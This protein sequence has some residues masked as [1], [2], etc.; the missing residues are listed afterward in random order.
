MPRVVLTDLFVRNLKATA[1]ATYW[2]K[3]LPGFGLR[4]GKRRKTFTVMLGQ[5]R[6]RLTIGHYPA[7]TLAEARK[8]AL[9]LTDVHRSTTPRDFSF[10]L[11][12][13]IE[14]HC[15]R[16]NKPSTA[17]ET[18]RL[19]RRLPF[20]G[21][22]HEITKTDIKQYLDT[23]SRSSANHAFTA[24]KTF[25]N[26]CVERDYLASNP[27]TGKKPFKDGSRERALSLDEVAL[28]LRTAD[29]RLHYDQI[30][31]LLLHTG[32]RR[33]EIAGLRREFVH[34]DLCTLPPSLTKNNSQHTF[35]LS[36]PALVIL[37]TFPFQPFH[38]WNRHKEAFDT[39]CPLPH[40][41]LHDLRRT[42]STIH[43][44]IGTPPHVTECL[45]NHRTGTRTPIQRVYDR[46]TYIPE[47]REAMQHYS[48]HLETLC[49]SPF[50]L[51][52][53]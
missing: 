37:D 42:F 20:A 52:D 27:L 23:L 35:V 51:P 19:L 21:P 41:T 7:M 1:H 8:K 32:Q 46:H 6:Q 38:N 34:G 53:H 31:L 49:A 47:M 26:W 13:F 40:W 36:K 2:D 14:M 5:D 50:I 18:E 30:V 45:L 10:A 33:G 25:L 29:R 24:T 11:D 44:S 3:N 43:A 15:K 28:L 17:K 39:K 9:M 48:A 16:N 22:L 4:S 12:A